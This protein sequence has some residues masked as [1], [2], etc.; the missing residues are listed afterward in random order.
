[1]DAHSNAAVAAPTL[2]RPSPLQAIFV[3]AVLV[4]IIAGYIIIGPKIGVEAL[5]MGFLFSTYWG[6]IR[7]LAIPDF[8]PSVF[9][10]LAG[11]GN[12]YLFHALPGALGASGAFL[13]LGATL[14]AMY[15]MIRQHAPMFLNPAFI[16]FLTVATIPVLGTKSEDYLNMAIG[17]V[18]ATAY[19]G[20]IVFVMGKI[21]GMR[22]AKSA[23]A[24]PAFDPA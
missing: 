23:T 1:M 10:A 15:F 4:P 9:G 2:A 16:V 17:V 6:A 20:A 8:L 14:L 12:A 11:I 5:Y 24:T 18:F 21:A 3:I 19:A 7:M 13:A 22:R